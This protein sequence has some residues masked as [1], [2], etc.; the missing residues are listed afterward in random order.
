MLDRAPAPPDAV[1]V[2]FGETMPEGWAL[3]GNVDEWT[4]GACAEPTATSLRSTPRT[5]LQI[6]LNAGRVVLSGRVGAAAKDGVWFSIGSWAEIPSPKEHTQFGDAEIDCTGAMDPANRF[7]CATTLDIQ[8]KLNRV[9]HLTEGGIAASEATGAMKVVRGAE[10]VST[11]SVGGELTFEA[12][13]P[14]AALPRFVARGVNKIGGCAGFD[15]L[16]LDKH[17]DATDLSTHQFDPRAA[18][19]L[20]VD[21][22]CEGVFAYFAFDS[23]DITVCR[24]PALTLECRDLPAFAL[25]AENDDVR[26]GLSPAFRDDN[27]L[28]FV[29][30]IELKSGGA[31]VQLF[32]AD[33]GDVL[34]IVGRARTIHVIKL[35]KKC[36]PR[37]CFAAFSLYRVGADGE[38]NSIFPVGDDE[39]EFR[40]AT[41]FHNADWKEFGIRGTSFEEGKPI[42]VRFTY[43]A[44]SDGYSVTTK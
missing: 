36:V 18:E 28:A 22:A 40:T 2:R 4:N 8:K 30:A 35:Q 23:P 34:K 33:Y 39:R 42:E 11:R 13:L 1:A 38:L 15:R 20:S 19:H 43:D 9:Y 26:V 37:D 7:A 10:L 3:D 27:T 16:P 29:P 6:T 25:Q 24:R 14:L 31:V 21:C 5:C 17:C 32:D 41:V 44:A 12:T